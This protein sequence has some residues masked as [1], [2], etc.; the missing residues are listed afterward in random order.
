M[1]WRHGNTAGKQ[2]EIRKIIEEDSDAYRALR[3]EA[4]LDSPT[5]FGSDHERE[6]AFDREQFNRGLNPDGETRPEGPGGG[7]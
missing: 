4:L 3:L 6:A 7:G 5:A 1:A 2:M